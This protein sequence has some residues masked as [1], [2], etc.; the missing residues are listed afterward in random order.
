MTEEVTDAEDGEFP[1]LGD[2][3]DW[4]TD[5]AGAHLTPPAASDD[6]VKIAARAVFDRLCPGI[7]YTASDAE[8]YEQALSTPTKAS[9]VDEVE[10][11]SRDRQIFANACAKADAFMDGSV[12]ELAKAAGRLVAATDNQEEL[13]AERQAVLDALTHLKDSSTIDPR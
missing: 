9:A 8:A 5:L 6:A 1:S 3:L 4:R 13:R 10:R 11:A 12:F 2:I 7:Q